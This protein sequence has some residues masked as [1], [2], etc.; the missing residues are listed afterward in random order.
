LQEEP[1]SC[2]LEAFAI[3]AWL[4]WDEEAIRWRVP[5]EISRADLELLVER[6]TVLL[7]RDEHRLIHETDFQ[8]WGRRG[9]RIKT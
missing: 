7:E 8:R 3:Q 5:V 9:G 4:S 6:S 1:T 2:G